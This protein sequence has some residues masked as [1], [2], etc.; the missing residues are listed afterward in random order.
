MKH[1]AWTTLLL[2]LLILAGCATYTGVGSEVWYKQR[3]DELEAIH[4]KGKI[5]DAEYLNSKNQIDQT[6]VDY[7]QTGYPPPHI[8][9]GYRRHY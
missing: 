9:V 5:T 3:M 6:Y 8:G 4:S 7:N 2:G 1:M